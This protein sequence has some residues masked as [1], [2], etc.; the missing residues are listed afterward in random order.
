MKP[1]ATATG[2]PQDGRWKI[3]LSFDGRRFCVPALE[4]RP[5]TNL[6]HSKAARKPLARCRLFAYGPADATAVPKLHR[7]LPQLNP[8]LFYLSGTGLPRLSRKRGR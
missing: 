8:D 3:T 4:L 7:L 5:K 1:E 2:D 6:V